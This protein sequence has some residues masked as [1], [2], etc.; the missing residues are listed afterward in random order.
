MAVIDDETF[1]GCKLF[2]SIQE[3]VATDF[4]NFLIPLGGIA[5]YYA[6]GLGADPFSIFVDGEHALT[7]LSHGRLTTINN[8][9]LLVGMIFW[10]G[11]KYLNIGTVITAFTTGPLIDYFLQL[12]RTTVPNPNNVFLINIGILILGCITFAVGVG[13]YIA[14]SLGVGPVEFISL[15]MVDRTKYP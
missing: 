1:A 13:L 11:R 14:L 4:A 9:V 2:V 7:G 6:C 15:F 8:I 5:G 12:I 10:G 3:T